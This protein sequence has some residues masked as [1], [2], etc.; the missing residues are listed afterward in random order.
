MNLFLFN[1][2]RSLECSVVNFFSK[3]IMFLTSKALLDF[4]INLLLFMNSICFSLKLSMLTYITINYLIF[5]AHLFHFY[6]ELLVNSFHNIHI[7]SFLF[8]AHFFE[9]FAFFHRCCLLNSYMILFSEQQTLAS[10]SPPPI[11]PSLIQWPFYFSIS[12]IVYLIRNLK[13]QII[14]QHLLQ[15]LRKYLLIYLDY[16]V[17]CIHVTQFCFFFIFNFT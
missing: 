7:L 5:L 17:V 1:V 14:F 15:C 12:K 2:L 3:Y 13:Y 8:R 4:N 9:S 11:H 6:I 10:Y 16:K